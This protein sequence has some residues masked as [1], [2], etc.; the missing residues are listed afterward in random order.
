MSM[1]ERTPTLTQAPVV[2]HHADTAAKLNEKV[3]ARGLNFF[4]G[5]HRALKDINVP[6]RRA[7]DPSSLPELRM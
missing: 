7:A 4:Y 2:T 5:D 6:L 1:V 3:S